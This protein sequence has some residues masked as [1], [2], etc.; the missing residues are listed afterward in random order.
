MSTAFIIVALF[1]F[2]IC[3]AGAVHLI[4][5]HGSL[6][7]IWRNRDP[8]RDSWFFEQRE[9]A[10]EVLK[11]VHDGQSHFLR[12]RL[13]TWYLSRRDTHR[14]TYLADPP[15]ISQPMP[16][17]QREDLLKRADRVHEETGEFLRV[18]G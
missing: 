16:A 8:F 2:V 4:R 6:G 9:S 15:P 12:G 5:I 11:A 13:R 3:L 18:K 10:A 7:E 1:F 17:I 14:K